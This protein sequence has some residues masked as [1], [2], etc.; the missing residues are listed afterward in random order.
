MGGGVVT[1]EKRLRASLTKLRQVMA[2]PTAEEIEQ[3]LK[4]QARNLIQ[5][6]PSPAD[7]N[8]LPQLAARIQALEHEIAQ[9]RAS[10]AR[11]IRAIIAAA[12]AA[13][14]NLLA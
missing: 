12:A 6:A 4:D 14:L 7:I 1:G 11:L 3:E 13:L 2:G 8:T 9:L 5:A 10:D